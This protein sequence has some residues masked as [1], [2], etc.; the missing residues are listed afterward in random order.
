MT[1]AFLYPFISEGCNQFEVSI[2][3]RISPLA[4]GSENGP[5]PRKLRGHL[6]LPESQSGIFWMGGKRT[7]EA[8]RR[9]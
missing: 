8:F 2:P 3:S 5:V 4:I 9:H 7:Q 1:W 6:F